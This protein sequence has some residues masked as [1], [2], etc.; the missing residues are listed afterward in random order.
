MV[1]K[2]RLFQVE[3]CQLLPNFRHE[4]ARGPMTLDRA[5]TSRGFVRLATSAGLSFF[6]L[7]IFQLLNSSVQLGPIVLRD[8]WRHDPL[9]LL[10]LPSSSLPDVAR[11]LE[12]VLSPE[13]Q[14]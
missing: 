12:R 5:S 7:N 1:I 14:S 13:Q 2:A 4:C 11:Q 8:S 10:N 3:G 9:P 6:E